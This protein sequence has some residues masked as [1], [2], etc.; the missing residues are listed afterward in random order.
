MVLHFPAAF[1]RTAV[2]ETDAIIACVN[3]PLVL[4]SK[5]TAFIDDNESFDNRT[6]CSD[7]KHR[8][9]IDINE[10]STGM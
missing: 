4:L 3:E 8:A 10:C 1:L 2:Q 6:S 9:F 5:H 7:I